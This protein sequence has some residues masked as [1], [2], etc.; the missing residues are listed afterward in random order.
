MRLRYFW[1]Q[2]YS[3]TMTTVKDIANVKPVWER[4][5]DYL[6]KGDTIGAEVS[7]A[8]EIFS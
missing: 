7:D 6:Q 4:L 2:F 1:E 3:T 8:Y 5:A